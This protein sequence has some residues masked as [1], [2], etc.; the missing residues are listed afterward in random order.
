MHPWIVPTE[1]D[2]GMTSFITLGFVDT[3]VDPT[4]ELIKKELDR[5]IAIRREVREDEPN[6]EALHDQPTATDLCASS[7]GVV[8]EV[9]DIG[10]KHIDAAG[11]LKKVEIYVELGTKE[12]KDLRR[13]KNA[14]KG[15]QDYPIHTFSS[16]DFKSM[17]D[18]RTYYMDKRTLFNR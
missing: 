6:V 5:A 7:R 9:I 3:I 8:G 14:K 18:M 17:K 1:Q 4:V 12:K 16:Q 11:P 13:A 15:T 10:G 2:L